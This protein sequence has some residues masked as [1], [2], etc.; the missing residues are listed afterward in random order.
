MSRKR[1][2]FKL[3]DRQVV[4]PFAAEEIKEYIEALIQQTK[5]AQKPPKRKD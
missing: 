1:D 3:I 2:I 4:N 5:A